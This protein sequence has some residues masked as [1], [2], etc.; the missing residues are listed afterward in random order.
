MKQLFGIPCLV[1]VSF[2]IISII[3]PISPA[4]SAEVTLTYSNFFPPANK[5]SVMSEQWCKEVE[6]RTNGRVK[7]NYF[8]G[9]A[10]TKPAQTYDA[11]VK[12]IADIGLT[13]V[14]YTRG[15]FPL[16]AL[17]ELPLGVTTAYEGTKLANAYYE[18]F[19]PKELD[20]VKLIYFHSSPPHHLFAK[21][22][23]PTIGDIK[24]LKLR[25]GGSAGEGVEALGAVP[26]S[27]PM[28]DAYDALAKGVV[29]GIEA[30][31]EPMKGFRL[32]EVV[33]HCTI[34]EQF[35][36]GLAFV[37]MNKGKWNS[38][39]PD[40]KETID[41]INGEWI[42]KQ[43]RLWDELEQEGKDVFLQK[44]GKILRFSDAEYEQLAEEMQPILNQ[45]LKETKEKGLPGEEVLKF[46]KDYLKAHRK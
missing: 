35:Y 24:G 21:K 3:A 11:V 10:L 43:G 8:P 44:G 19:R 32:A 34:L 2:F 36:A 40:I 9:S 46:C 28:S 27:M 29:D 6:K 25:A 14:G 12:G 16:T 1:V 41:K 38:L 7:V 5:V 4:A 13:F 30:P 17:F 20:D 26:V 33:N 42:E 18:K 22:P 39:A 37:V 15:R 23:I 45:Y 31:F